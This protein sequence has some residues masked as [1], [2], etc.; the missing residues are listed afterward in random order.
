M[1]LQISLHDSMIDLPGH[2]V[3]GVSVVVCIF[4]GSA[5]LPT[6]LSHIFSQEVPPHIP[7]E[8]IVVDNA[9]TD[10]TFSTARNCRPPENRVPYRVFS[11]PIPGVQFARIKA[12]KMARFSYL[13][14][15]DD[16]AWI[17]RNYVRTVYNTLND[18]PEVAVCGGDVSLETDK[19]PPDWFIAHQKAFAV[20]RQGEERGYIPPSPGVILGI[21]MGIRKSAWRELLDAGFRQIMNGRVAGNLTGGEDNELCFALQLV[22]WKLWYEPDLK[23]RH[24]ISSDRLTWNYLRDNRRGHGAARLWLAYY[25]ELLCPEK[26]KKL[27]TDKWVVFTVSI[28]GKLIQRWHHVVLGVAR[29]QGSTR[30]LKYEIRMGC[31]QEVIRNRHI[32]RQKVSGIREAPW[33]KLWRERGKDVLV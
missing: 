29:I 5:R 21:G 25:A 9:S 28:V 15:V 4:N 19:M 17:D 8:V 16:D 32:F 14:F 11:E 3:K 26:Q 22:G 23:V 33:L 20:G 27:M 31:L 6:T 30:A 24:A 1:E 12:L 13:C 7:W 2:E 18:H 10:G